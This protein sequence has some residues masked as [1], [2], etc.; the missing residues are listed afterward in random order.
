MKDPRNRKTLKGSGGQDRV[1]PP[2]PSRRHVDLDD[3]TAVRRGVIE[4]N[5]LFV[6]DMNRAKASVL[7]Q[8]QA[9]T[10]EASLDQVHLHHAIYLLPSRRASSAQ[11]LR[12]PPIRPAP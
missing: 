2:V 9:Q 7:I 3:S 8:R 11:P 10:L 1:L 12:G 4:H 6:F 5:P